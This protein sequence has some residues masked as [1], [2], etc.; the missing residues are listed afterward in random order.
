[1]NDVKVMRHLVLAFV[2]VSTGAAL[3]AESPAP[4]VPTSSR[5]SVSQLLREAGAAI[6]GEGKLGRLKALV[7]QGT[8]RSGFNGATP[9]LLEARSVEYRVL[10]PDNYLRITNDNEVLHLH[11][12]A[13]GIALRQMKP[14]QGDVRV[15]SSSPTASL[16]PFSRTESARL[17]LGILADTR[18]GLQMEVRAAPSAEI[19]LDLKILGDDPPRP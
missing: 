10:L 16:L 5:P 17:V 7:L 6:G 14:L 18:T 4:A 15:G 11:G 12:F 9:Q 8:T 1:M 2:L 19:E 3:V 13:G